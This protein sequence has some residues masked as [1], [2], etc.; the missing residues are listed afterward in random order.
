MRATL[1]DPSGSP[2]ASRLG[3][4]LSL[5][6]ACSEDAPQVGMPSLSTSVAIFFQGA[7]TEW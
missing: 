7:A 4:V 3:V 2:H 6:E 1:G 5:S